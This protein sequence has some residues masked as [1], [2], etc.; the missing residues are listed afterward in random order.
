MEAKNGKRKQKTRGANRT[1]KTASLAVRSKRTNSRAVGDKSGTSRSKL[2]KGLRT[3][4]RPDSPNTKPASRKSESR[5][6]PLDASRK[7]PSNVERIPGNK[8]YSEGAPGRLSN[9]NSKHVRKHLRKISRCYAYM[10]HVVR[11]FGKPTG[12][13][14][15]SFS[16]RAKAGDKTLLH[17]CVSRCIRDLEIIAEALDAEIEPDPT[18]FMPGTEKKIE[19]L[20]ER[21]N[22]GQKIFSEQDVSLHGGD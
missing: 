14:T 21:F 20:R 9:P 11:A 6:R 16:L 22:N 3:T 19:V 17:D 15:D 10:C 7:K 12:T 8:T 1:N 2:T 5:T 18:E 13:R 4:R